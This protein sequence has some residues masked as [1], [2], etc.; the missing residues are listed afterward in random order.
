MFRR[1]SWCGRSTFQNGGVGVL[2]DGA[3]GV[4][5]SRAALAPEY[6]NERGR[7]LVWVS[8]KAT[9]PRGVT[10]ARVIPR[11]QQVCLFGQHALQCQGRRRRSAKQ[12]SRSQTQIKGQLPPHR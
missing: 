9:V 5:A 6:G 8:L 1:C 3:L 10:R 2:R 12:S 11:C 4:R 7:R